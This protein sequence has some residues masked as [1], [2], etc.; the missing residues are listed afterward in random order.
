MDPPNPQG[1]ELSGSQAWKQDSRKTARGQDLS[2][3]PEVLIPDSLIQT[4]KIV[5]LEASSLVTVQTNNSLPTYPRL[6]SYRAQQGTPTYTPQ[7]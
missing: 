1:T 5:L 7:A 4:V 6:K 3:K 2:F